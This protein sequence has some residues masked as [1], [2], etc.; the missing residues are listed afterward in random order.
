M[1]PEGEWVEKFNVTYDIH[2]WGQYKD[3]KVYTSFLDWFDP[4][5]K[6]IYDAWKRVPGLPVPKDGASG[7]GGLFYFPISLDPK[8]QQRSY[9]RTGHWD[10]LNRSNYHI[11][12]GSKVNKILFSGKKA[13][14]VRFVPKENPQADATIIRARREIIISAG[15]VHTPQILQLSGIG[16]AD[17]LKQAKVSVK[18]DLPGVGSNFQD[19]PLGPLLEWQCK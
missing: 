15:G 19:H 14:A 1:P 18:V 11:V 2:A 8:T 6:V 13:V 16:P 17:L 4:I 12:T 10:G 3:T 5:Q 9:A 7:V